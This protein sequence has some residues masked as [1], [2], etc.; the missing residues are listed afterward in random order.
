MCE[1]I[2]WIEKNGEIFYL[3]SEDLQGKSF[4]KFKKE[5]SN[6]KKDIAGHG[7]IELFYPESKNG[8]HK[9]C[10]NFSNPS[11]FPE[12]IVKTIKAGKFRGIGICLDVLNKSA[13]DKYE[14]IEQS[15]WKEYEKIEQPARKEYEKIEQSARKEYE[16]I[17]QEMF[18][19]II[20]NPKNRKKIWK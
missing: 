8:K 1:F 7:T 15:A 2:S 9:E 4:L 19:K 14:K 16:K 13:L 6:W 10:T 20:K 5:N 18:W 12:I 17:K 11:N 3:T